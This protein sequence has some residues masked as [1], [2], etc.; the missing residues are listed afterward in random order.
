MLHNICIDRWVIENPVVKFSANGERVWPNPEEHD[1]V[2]DASPEDDEIIE[3]LHNNYVDAK[4]VS[5]D[6][7][8]KRKLTQDIYDAGIRTRIYT[9]FHQI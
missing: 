2:H 9:E 4:R 7:S 8:I 6:N 1:N 3:R 5:T